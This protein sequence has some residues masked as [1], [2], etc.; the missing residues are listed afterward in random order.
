MSRRGRGVTAHACLGSGLLK[1]GFNA[2]WP[3][4]YR[5]SGVMAF[6]GRLPKKDLGRDTAK[7][8]DARMECNPD[9]TWTEVGP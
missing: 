2:G 3:A 7:L 6:L 1:M 9:D 4:D 8:A 5:A